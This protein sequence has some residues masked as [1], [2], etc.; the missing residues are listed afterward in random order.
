M[1]K[2]H[3]DRKPLDTATFMRWALL[4]P[5]LLPVLLLI[6]HG[7]IKQFPAMNE[8]RYSG[9]YELGGFIVFASMLGLVPYLIFVTISWKKL[10]TK[11]RI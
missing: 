10:K 6:A 3:E 5:L 1:N 4:A 8:L 9:V 11:S 2:P 7:I